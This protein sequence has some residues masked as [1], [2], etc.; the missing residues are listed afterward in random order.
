MPNG[1][2]DCAYASNDPLCQIYESVRDYMLDLLS[3]IRNVLNDVW[4][5]L[6][7]ASSITSSCL[8]IIVAEHA[9]SRSDLTRLL[10]VL[11]ARPVDVVKKDDD[12]WSPRQS[13]P[14]SQ[15]FFTG[16]GSESAFLSHFL[17]APGNH[18]STTSGQFSNNALRADLQRTQQTGKLCHPPVRY[19]CLL[20]SPATPLLLPRQREPELNSHFCLTTGAR[21][22]RLLVHAEFRGCPEHL[23]LMGCLV[24]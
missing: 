16:L 13:H 8:I 14:Y 23:T 22:E 10:L 18:P 6:A 9:P 11:Q 21:K 1:L 5:Y 4:D 19:A 15:P 2:Y 7:Q 20:P 12:L 3:W 17:P 24:K